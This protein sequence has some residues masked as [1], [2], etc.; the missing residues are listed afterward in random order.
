M[1]HGT[2]T[3]TR[4]GSRAIETLSSVVSLAAIVGITSWAC[5]LATGAGVI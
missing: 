4:Q 3:R 5:T 2:Q 1:S